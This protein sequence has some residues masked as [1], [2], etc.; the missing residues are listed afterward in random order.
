MAHNDEKT[1]PM[2][3]GKYLADERDKVIVR[4]SVLSILANILL[5]SFKAAVGLLAH[6]ISVILDAVNNLSDALSSIITI[7]GTKLAKKPANKK[8]PYGYGRIE[9]ISAVVISVI[10]LYAGC[11]AFKESVVKIFRPQKAEYSVVTL[12]IV[13]LAVA[14]KLLLGTYVKAA[15]KK[16][17]SKSL[18]ASGEDAR[19]D[20]ILSTS[21]LAAALIQKFTGFSVEAYVGVLI[22]VFILKSGYEMLSDTLGDILGVRIDPEVSKA[23]KETVCKVPGVHG[24]YDLFLNDYGPNQLQGSVHIELDEDT[25]AD[26]IDQLS[27]EIIRNVYLKNHVILTA[28]GIYSHNKSNSLVV[29][30]REKVRELLKGYKDVLQMHGFYMNEESKVLK[31]DV[32]I[33][34]DAKDREQEYTEILG[35]VRALFPDYSVRMNLDADMSD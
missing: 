4:T 21:V 8:H 9:Y 10:V 20:A 1:P 16:V 35:K 29:E 31:F 18:V 15:G 3:D 32:I 25:T 28:V 17:D 23:V 19:N 11:T 7:I 33:S 24:A 34:F 5:A 27:T 14:V 22:S 13:A 2:R 12:V 26:K 6:S 30:S